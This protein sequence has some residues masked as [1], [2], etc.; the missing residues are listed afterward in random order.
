MDNSKSWLGKSYEILNDIPNVE[1]FALEKK[2]GRYAT[3]AETVGNGIIDH[4]ISTNTIHLIPD[5]K[6]AFIG[7]SNALKKD[8]TFTFQ[9]GNFT[10]KDRSEGALMIDDTVN[11]VHDMALETVRVDPRFESYREDLDKNIETQGIQRKFVFPDPKPIEFYL[12]V[13]KESGFEHQAPLFT[14]V[15]IMYD[16]WLNF[17]RV[18]RL[19]AGILP[20]IGGKESSPKAEQDRDTLITESALKLFK[21]LKANNPLANDEGFIIDCVHVLSRKI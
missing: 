9:T 6:D 13:L 2:D 11:D 18:K 4:V 10:R 16:D 12:K 17:L 19:Q 3:L 14:P 8:G 15:R 1:F 21:N 7:I 20:E 5:L